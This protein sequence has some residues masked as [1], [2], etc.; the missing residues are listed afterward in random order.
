MIKRRIEFQSLRSVDLAVGILN[1]GHKV[2]TAISH[3]RCT[4]AVFRP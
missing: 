1:G 2:K 3:Q 4:T